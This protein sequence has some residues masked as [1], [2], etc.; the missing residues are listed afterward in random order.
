MYVQT[1][2]KSRLA[3]LTVKLAWTFI[4]TAAILSITISPINVCACTHRGFL[5]GWMTCQIERIV[6]T[7]RGVRAAPTAPWRRKRRNPKRRRRGKQNSERKRTMRT[8]MTTM[9]GTWRF[10]HRNSLLCSISQGNK[11]ITVSHVTPGTKV[12]QSADARVGSRRC[13]VCL[14]RGRL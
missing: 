2:L 10:S 13:A 3:L 14:L 9:M 7:G 1:P 5:A 12:I 11:W 6:V 8:M 4:P